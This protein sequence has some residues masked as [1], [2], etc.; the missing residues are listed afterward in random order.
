[1]D[2]RRRPGRPSGHSSHRHPGPRNAPRSASFSI[3]HHPC[4][5]VP[6][7]PSATPRRPQPRPPAARLN[8]GRTHFINALPG[9][10]APRPPSLATTGASRPA[11]PT[12]QTVGPGPPRPQPTAFRTTAPCTPAPPTTSPRPTPDPGSQ[13]EY[14]AYSFHQRIIWQLRTSPPRPQRPLMRPAP[15]CPHR[16]PEPRTTPPQPTSPQATTPAP[17]SQHRHRSPCVRT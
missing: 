3:D 16:Q 15:P 4:T 14:S 12:P 8:T 5:P 1:M 6:A 2:I 11:S 10:S 9:N 17:D 7:L 13:V